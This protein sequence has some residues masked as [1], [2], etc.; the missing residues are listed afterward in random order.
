MASHHSYTGAGGMSAA[1]PGAPRVCPAHPAATL[2]AALRASLRPKCHAV[3]LDGALVSAR[4]AAL[5]IHD[6]CVVAAAKMLVLLRRARGS[7]AVGPQGLRTQTVVAILVEAI[8]Y[9]DV[10]VRLR[11]PA[12]RYGEANVPVAALEVVT[13]RNSATA[14]CRLVLGPALIT[15]LKGDTPPVINA[16]ATD[17]ARRSAALPLSTGEL[18][19]VALAAFARVFSRSEGALPG[20][21]RA[22]LAVRTQL[23]AASGTRRLRIRAS[24]VGLGDD[25]VGLAHALVMGERGRSRRK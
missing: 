3:L 6:I 17:A 1:V 9:L 11:C 23:C 15:D 19:W 20:V 4:T 22:L 12:P 24:V 18:L 8:G 25:A 10:L 13:G 14:P 16:S 7:A 21:M 2:A 5:N